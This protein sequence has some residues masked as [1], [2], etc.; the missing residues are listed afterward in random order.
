MERNYMLEAEQHRN[1]AENL[2]SKLRHVQLD[3]ECLKLKHEQQTK[4]IGEL[5][6]EVWRLRANL[7]LKPSDKQEAE[8]VVYMATLEVESECWK[9]SAEAYRKALEEISEGRYGEA[10]GKE[11]PNAWKLAKGALSGEKEA[12]DRRECG[13]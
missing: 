6:D 7:K 5:T 8:R 2:R 13:E 4:T 10:S 11:Y 1:E 12:K 9:E 3:H